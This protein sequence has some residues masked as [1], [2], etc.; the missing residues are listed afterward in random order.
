VFVARAQ[1]LRGRRSPKAAMGLFRYSIA[2]LALLFGAVA[3][4]TIV[5]HGL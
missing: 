5:R 3:L 4:D 1:H 2:Y